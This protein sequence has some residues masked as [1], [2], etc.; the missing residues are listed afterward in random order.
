MPTKEEKHQFELLIIGIVEKEGIT[1]MEAILEHCAK[2]GLE[3]EVA[4]TLT[5]PTLRS[6]I[7]TEA[8]ALRYLPKSSTLPL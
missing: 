5:S 3:V 1:H 7:E 4:A 2:T 8:R 6:K